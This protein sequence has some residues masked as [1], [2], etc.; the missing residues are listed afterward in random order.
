MSTVENTSVIDAPIEAVFKY[1]DEPMN[2]P[3]VTPGVDRVE[4]LRTT[5][6]RIGDSIRLVY[7]VMKLDFPMTIVRTAHEPPSM[8]AWTLQGAMSGELR[9]HLRE[10]GPEETEASVRVEYEVKGGAVGKAVDSLVLERMNE[11]NGHTML[12]NVKQR[13][14]SR[15]TTGI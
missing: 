2:I 6:E 8:V 5:D 13:L 11:K 9:W 7:S 15:A 14:E 4:V 12:E 1:V 10:V 3:E